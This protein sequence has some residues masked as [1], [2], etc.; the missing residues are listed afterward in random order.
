MQRGSGGR[1]STVG[2]VTQSVAGILYPTYFHS[3]ARTLTRARF[4]IDGKLIDIAWFAIQCTSMKST[5]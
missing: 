3:P 2:H 1:H 4:C 5:R